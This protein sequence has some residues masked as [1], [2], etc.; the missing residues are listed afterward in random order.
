LAVTAGLIDNL[1]MVITVDTA[2][3]HLSAGMGVDTRLLLCSS[4]DWR[5]INGNKPDLW[6]PGL[7]IYKQEEPGDWSLP[8]KRLGIDLDQEIPSLS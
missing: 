5:W 6:Y 4:P 2:V 8:L 7:R 1:D 3:A